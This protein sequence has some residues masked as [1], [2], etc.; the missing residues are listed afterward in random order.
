MS[1]QS[2]PRVPARERIWGPVL[3]ADEH[4]AALVAR[5]WQAERAGPALAV[6][7]A[8]DGV[9]EQATRSA[10]GGAVRAARRLGLALALLGRARSLHRAGALADARDALGQARHATGTANTAALLLVRAECGREESLFCLEADRLA[11]GRAAIWQALREFATVDAQDQMAAAMILAM[12]IDLKM[13][14]DAAEAIRHGE[15]ARRTLAAYGDR[16]EIAGAEEF[17]AE[18]TS[19]TGDVRAASAHLA[20]AW[21]NRRLSD[22]AAG[23]RRCL[24]G[25]M[26]LVRHVPQDVIGGLGELPW[27]ETGAQ[28]AAAGPQLPLAL[29]ADSRTRGDEELAVRLFDLAIATAEGAGNVPAQAEA[30]Y[31]AGVALSALYSAE[32]PGELA[33]ARELFAG[34]GDARGVARCDFALATELGWLGQLT[35]AGQHLDRAI[36]TFARLGQEGDAARARILRGQLLVEAGRP[37]EAVQELL[38][39]QAGLRTL[40]Q[41]DETGAADTG[42]AQAYRALG[43]AEAA[44]RHLASARARYAAAGDGRRAAVTDALTAEWL[45]AD[46]DRDAGPGAASAAELAAG[47]ESALRAVSV[48]EAMRHGLG[49]AA[50]R[51][52]WVRGHRAKT[53]LAIELALRAGDPALVAELAETARAQALPAGPDPAGARTP[54]AAGTAAAELMSWTATP[55]GALTG[56]FDEITPPL[57]PDDRSRAAA[58]FAFGAAPLATLPRIAVGGRSRLAGTARPGTAPSG[59]DVVDLN[60]LVRTIGGPR[61]WWWGASITAFGRTGKPRL[62]WTVLA[63]SGQVQAGTVALDE[64]GAIIGELLD[65][66]PVPG[67]S[68]AEF[69]RRLGRPIWTDPRAE[70]RLMRRLGELLLP[71]P[72]V[73]A[74]S[75]A[76]ED[77]PVPVL[78]ATDP[79][80]SRLPLALLG[81]PDGRRLVNLAVPRL[82]PSAGLS[83]ALAS[84]RAPAPPGTPRRLELVVADPQGQHPAAARLATLPEA[85]VSLTGAGAT[86][87]AVLAALP[88]GPV[89]PGVF[90]FSGHVFSGFPGVSLTAAL[91]LADGGLADGSLGGVGAGG[92]GRLS[93][94]DLVTGAA[95]GMWDRVLLAGCS[96][97]GNSV[98]SEWLGLAPALLYA[99]AASVVATIWDIPDHTSATELDREILDGLRD[100]AD[101]AAVVR[102]AQVRRLARWADSA[103]TDVTGMTASQLLGV[104]PHP[105]IFGGYTTVS[106]E[107]PAPGAAG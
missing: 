35:E 39:G 100:S 27:L 13:G 79:A 59:T 50:A 14:M 33:R 95:D 57:T 70:A 12:R 94:R 46:A 62:L 93:A 8:W 99:G 78:I 56:Q 102:V 61:A 25:L 9:R 107:P 97:A 45:L 103:G 16:R 76:H 89:R 90:A 2:Q 24:D 42:L 87:E 104:R 47:L 98:G 40:D 29:G 74:L 6:L 17:L 71:P 43:D 63:P 20:R 34:L 1:E 84:G 82:M 26:Q 5:A 83:H 54:V 23:A 18:V 96:S 22:D 69:G 77:E 49:S 81:L 101:P 4:L 68:R 73:S 21:L 51:E 65:A 31:Q 106:L 10:L 80:L 48:L 30:S 44:A 28:A 75:S 64:A 41:Q 52:D 3:A 92:A 67:V 53:G 38:A 32:A 72:L 19:R 88:A 60:A 55:V 36:R 105:L 37:R 91:C 15:T 7:A 58:M 86:R 66:L 11:E 85:Q